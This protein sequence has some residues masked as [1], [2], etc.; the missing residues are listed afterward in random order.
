MPGNPAGGRG[1][2]RRRRIGGPTAGRLGARS[3][4]TGCAAPRWGPTCWSGG[5]TRRRPPRPRRPGTLPCPSCRTPVPRLASGWR[6]SGSDAHVVSTDLAGTRRRAARTR[7][8]AGRTT[9]GTAPVR[10]PAHA[11]VSRTAGPRTGSTSRS[12]P[13]TGTAR[14]TSRPRRAAACSGSTVS[15]LRRGSRWSTPVTGWASG[16]TS[17]RP[18]VRRTIRSRVPRWETWAGTSCRW[19]STTWSGPHD[20][21]ACARGHGDVDPSHAAGE[22]SNPVR[23]PGSRGVRGRSAGPGASPSSRCHRFDRG[24]GRG[25]PGQGRAHPVGVAGAERLTA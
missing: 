3:G 1:S 10:P 5:E 14:C 9:S 25:T 20:A 12:P 24:G 16:S 22:R 17:C 23:L 4:R 19:S 2:G 7:P 13:T 6:P 15:A 21:G 18:R 11:V 8:T